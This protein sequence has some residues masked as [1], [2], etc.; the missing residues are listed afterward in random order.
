MTHHVMIT[1][2]LDSEPCD[3]ES[4]IDHGPP[5]RDAPGYGCLLTEDNDMEAFAALPDCEHCDGT[6]KN[7]TGSPWEQD[8]S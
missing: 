4:E 8:L 1:G 6:G 7:L 5:L 2:L 3:C